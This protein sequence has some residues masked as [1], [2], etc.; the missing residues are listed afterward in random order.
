MISL[1]PLI[2]F[3]VKVISRS[4]D[5]GFCSLILLLKLMTT[6]TGGSLFYLSLLKDLSIEQPRGG[7]SKGINVM[8]IRRINFFRYV[9]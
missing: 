2:S 8:S 7:S 3:A 4:R 1:T 6:G 5:G 9:I